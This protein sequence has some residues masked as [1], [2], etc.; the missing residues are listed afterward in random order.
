MIIVGIL[1][2]VFGVI[3]FLKAVI[4]GQDFLGRPLYPD[5]APADVKLGIRI[6]Y[7]FLAIF[8]FAIGC[9]LVFGIEL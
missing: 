4:K 5:D 6:K 3:V 2:L 1:A 7:L 9:S 8:C